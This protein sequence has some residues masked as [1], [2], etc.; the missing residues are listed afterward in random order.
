MAHQQPAVG[1]AVKKLIKQFAEV[2]IGAKRISAGKRRIGAHAVPRS[3]PTQARAQSVKDIAFRIGEALWRQSRPAALPQPRLR[4]PLFDHAQ[5][6]LAD[7]REDVNV[8]VA[9]DII[10]IAAEGVAKRDK[11]AGNLGFEP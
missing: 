3:K 2:G 4:R 6:R 8:L 7:L 9:I 11:L 1:Q 10:W 5:E